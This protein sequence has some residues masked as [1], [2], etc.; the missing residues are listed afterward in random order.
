MLNISKNSINDA[1]DLQSFK[2]YKALKKGRVNKVSIGLVLLI[3]IISACTLF[4]PWTQNIQV[5]GYVTTQLPSQKPQG[6]QSII[7]GKIEK[8]Y[9]QEGD[10]VAK[11]DTIIFISEVKSEYFDPDLLERTDE[12]LTAKDLSIQSY[13]QKINALSQQAKTLEQSKLLKLQQTDNKILQTLN[14]IEADSMSLVALKAQQEIEQNQFQRIN[15]LYDKGLKSLSELQ[16][17]ELKVQANKAK[18]N[19][20]EN[21]LMVKR[22]ELINFKIELSSIEQEYNDKILKTRSDKQSAI[23]AKE[24]AIG[25]FSKLKSTKSNYTQR[26]EYY[27]ITAPQDGYITKILKKGMGEIVKESTNIATIMPASYDLATEMYIKPQDLPLIK[28]NDAVRLRFDGWPALVISGWPESSTGVFSGKVAVIDQFISENGFYRVLVFPDLEDRSWP[29]NLRVGTGTQSF[30][31]LSNV[32]VW[33]EFWRQL[34]GFPA[35][36]YDEI[37]KKSDAVKQKVPLRKVK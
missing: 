32:P 2:S 27:H 29:E 15:E 33:Y 7:S 10:Y 20:Q 8:W 11:G 25:S 22:N 28:K 17:K 16:A 23:A 3:I 6:V 35:N 5:K 24:D 14:K 13:E 21:K 34:N 4:L 12:Q 31:L 18:V 26:Q 9:V 30:I 37:E 19:A 36:F 1:V